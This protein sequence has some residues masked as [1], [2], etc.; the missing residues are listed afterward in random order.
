MNKTSIGIL[1]ILAGVLY[2][3]LAF[4]YINEKTLGWLINNNWLKLPSYSDKQKAD[5]SQF[6][7]NQ[8]TIIFYSLIL[9]GIGIYIIINN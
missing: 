3:S 6:F 7:G 1:F 4:P 5:S 8:G 9:I 2:G